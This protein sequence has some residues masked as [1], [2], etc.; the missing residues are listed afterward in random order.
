M[1]SRRRARVS[2][3]VWFGPFYGRLSLPTRRGGQAWGSVGARTGRHS[4][5]SVS[6][7]VGQRQAR[8]GPVPGRPAV[9]QPTVRDAIRVAWQR[10]RDRRG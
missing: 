10:H 2:E 9:M 7:P 3:T 6:F 5:T 8:R 4:E 1:R